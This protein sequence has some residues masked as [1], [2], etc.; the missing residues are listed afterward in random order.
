MNPP[1]SLARASS[2]L[3]L[4]VVMACILHVTGLDATGAL[5]QEKGVVPSDATAIPMP[6]P[7]PPARPSELSPAPQVEPAPKPPERP[8]ADAPS[9]PE[10]P[11]ELAAPAPAAS[12]PAISKPADPGPATDAGG[13]PLPP[14]RPPELSGATPLAVTVSPQDDTACRQRLERLGATFERLP[15]I[16][17]G[18][19][20]AALPLKVSNLAGGLALTPPATLVCGA[21][22]SLARWATE[23]QAAAERDL[24]QSLKSLSVGTSYECRGQN[25]DPDAKLSEHSYANGIDVMAF[26]FPARA[27][28]AVTALPEGS[29]EATFL[30]GIRA[31]A[32][33][34]FR[35]VL[36]P[37]SDPAHANHFH[38]D[39]R[40]R[41]AGHRL[42]Q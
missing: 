14:Q 33:G 27:A 5:A 2:A 17:N 32:C 18:Q 28:I 42:C 39:E 4:L 26:G 16:S 38:L 34:F 29:P 13:L 1:C 24:G 30:A 9:P 3:P 25:H 7:T 31:K 41:T 20:G 8:V 40:E 37:G 15:A 35:T 36:G 12:K 11:P 23:A 21:A 19:C 22:E 10:R 6:P